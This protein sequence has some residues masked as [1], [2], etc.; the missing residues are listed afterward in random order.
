MSLRNNLAGS[1][2]LLTIGGLIACS[3]P[4]ND[5]STGNDPAAELAAFKA[6][7]R[8]KYDMKEQAFRDNDPDPIV[9]KFYSERVISTNNEGV[10]HIGREEIR[11]VYE[12]VMGSI[13]RIESFDT[14][15]GGN[16]GWDWANFHVSFPPEANLAPF[17]FK[18]L[19]LWE[20]IDGEWWSDGEMYVLG[21]FDIPD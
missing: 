21:E 14:F 10:T 18:M 11:P 2:I 13:V 5:A 16:A 19:F 1:F 12:E 20:K 7:I 9:T 3:E 17:T 15:V 4:A 8:A 6:A